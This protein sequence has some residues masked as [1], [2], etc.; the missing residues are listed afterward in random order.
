MPQKIRTYK[1]SSG[2]ADGSGD[3]TATSARNIRGKV[4]AIGLVYDA[5]SDA[6]TDVTITTAGDIVAAQ[7]LLTATDNNTSKW[8]Y[9]RVPVEDATGTDVTYDGTNEIYE[10]FVISDRIVITVAD[11]TE[12][13]AVTVYLLVEEF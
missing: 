9:P 10:P 12:A 6:G 7:T 4:M 13:K 1:L 2:V 3:A 8:F 11:Q 5:G